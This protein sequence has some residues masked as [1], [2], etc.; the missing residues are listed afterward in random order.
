LTRAVGYAVAGLQ[1]HSRLQTMRIEAGAADGTAQ[2]K[3]KRIN[4]VTFR[5]LQSLGGEAGPD[6]SNMAPI[7]YRTTATP[8]GEPPAIG[9]DDC[10]VKWEKGYETKGRIA[11]RQ[12]APFPMTVIASCRRSLPTTRADADGG[13]AL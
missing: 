12:S 6:F 9:D 4:E 10:R 5:V 2:A 13:R 7:K 8:M 3:I 11:I 1:Y